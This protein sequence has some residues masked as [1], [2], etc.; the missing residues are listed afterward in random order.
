MCENITGL[1]LEPITQGTL[2]MPQPRVGFLSC[3]NYLDRN[4]FS[5]TLYSMHQ[6]LISQPLQVV[7]LGNAEMPSRWRQLRH[8]FHPQKTSLKLGSQDYIVEYTKFAY[9]VQKQLLKTPCDVIVAPVASEEL[10]FLSSNK[11]IIYLSDVTFRLYKK[12]YPL[13]LESEEIDWK[14]NQEKAAI[15]KSKKVIYSSEWAAKSAIDDYQADAEKVEVVPF[16]ANLD[17]PPLAEDV[18]GK[19]LSSPCRLLFVGKDWQRKGGTIAFDTLMALLG[20]GVEAELVVVGTIPPI[21]HEKLTVI[22]YLNKNVSQQRQQLNQLFLDSHFF[23]F[24]TRA[25]C[26]P[27]VICEANAFGLPVLTTEVG[28]IPT[29]VKN[30]N[31]GYMLPRSASGEEYAHLIAQTIS[32]PSTYQQLVHSSRREYDQRLNWDK[33]GE[34]MYQI[35]SD[36]VN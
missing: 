6:S 18:I 25:E 19:K 31:N 29:I 34:K 17:D 22:P 8:Y 26:S 28:G 5:G 20:R 16:G 24:P 13:A 14:E 21:Q 9:Q 15:L 2:A 23:I 10:S 35:I 12:Y 27:I 4:A 30:G 36:M 7:N 33:W 1:T 11:P 3:Q 32:D